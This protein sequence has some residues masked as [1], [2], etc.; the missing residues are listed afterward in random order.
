MKPHR[1]TFAVETAAGDDDP[2]IFLYFGDHV[3]IQVA[4]SL[5][6]FAE[7][8]ERLESMQDEIRDTYPSFH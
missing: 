6:E 7:V 2:A 3:R 4:G 8:I 5:S 1:I